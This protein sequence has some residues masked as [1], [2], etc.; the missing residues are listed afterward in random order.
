MF[1]DI[2][3]RFI[4]F[5]GML[6]FIFSVSISG[7]FAQG[8]K[9]TI[10]WLEPDFPPCFVHSGPYEGLG[11]EDVI[12]DIIQKRLDGYKFKTRRANVSRMYK[13]FKAGRKVCHVAFYRNQEREKFMH[14]S[15]PDTITFPVVLVTSKEKVG[16]FEG[17]KEVSLKEVLKNKELSVSLVKDRSYGAA[18]DKVLNK[19][20]HTD[21]VHWYVGDDIGEKPLKMVI[22]GRIDYTLALPEEV[23]YWA[24]K[25]GVRDRVK[26]IHLKENQGEFSSWLGYVACPKTEWGA[27]TIKNINRVLRKVRPLE[28]YRKAYERWIDEESIPRYRE[29][30]SD[31]F[32]KTGIEN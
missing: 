31:F 15:I 16:L 19:Y 10:T 18:L 32:L 3:K 13:E 4:L 17:Q 23:M 7:A 27:K 12:T 5:S 14:F 28:S 8:E 30:Y 9:D 6:I 20:G 11:Y 21:N 24:E 29:L 22:K 2:L 26:I 1:S 25:N